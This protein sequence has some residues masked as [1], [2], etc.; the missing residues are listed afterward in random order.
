MNSNTKKM[1]QKCIDEMKETHHKRREYHLQKS[2]ANGKQ[3]QI[4]KFHMENAMS[5]QDE[6]FIDDDSD[7]EDGIYEWCF[8]EDLSS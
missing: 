1:M 7:P 4:A 2:K 6:W 8:I 5:L 3:K